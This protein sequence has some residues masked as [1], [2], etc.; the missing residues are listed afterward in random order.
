M[1]VH[2]D[3]DFDPPTEKQQGFL[4]RH[5]LIPDRQPDFYEAPSVIGRFIRSCRRLAPTARQK[6][7]LQDHR[8]WKEGMTRGEAFD[9]IS[10]C[11][12]ADESERASER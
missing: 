4:D 2:D 5:N 11:K 1:N 10:Q 9:L 6:H 12:A 7:F 3:E 8:L